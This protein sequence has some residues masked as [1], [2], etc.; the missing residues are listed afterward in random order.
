LAGGGELMGPAT[1]S[2][3]GKFQNAHSNF[4]CNNET[5]GENFQKGEQ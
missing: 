4:T 2:E 3:E 5:V 1:K